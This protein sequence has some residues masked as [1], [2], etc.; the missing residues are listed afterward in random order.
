MHALSSL[1]SSISL[2]LPE[3]YKPYIITFEQNEESGVDKLSRALTKRGSEPVGMF[4]LSIMLHLTGKSAEAINIAEKARYMV[5]G[6]SFFMGLP[7]RLKHPEGFEAWVP[8][9]LGLNEAEP[10]ISEVITAPAAELDELIVVLSDVENTKIKLVD[11]PIDND[12]YYN[13]AEEQV[14]DI[15]TETLAKI[16]FNQNEF[17]RSLAIYNRL[18]E[19]HPEKEALYNRMILKIQKKLQ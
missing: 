8:S 15:Y 4:L 3:T 19:L 12:N 11:K 18:V 13:T 1:L 9:D 14:D 10:I 5:A 17:E 16:Y 7:Y 6:S 2:T